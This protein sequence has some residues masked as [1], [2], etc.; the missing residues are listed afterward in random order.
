MC[1]IIKTRRGSELATWAIKTPAQAPSQHSH[2]TKHPKVV[3]LS[4]GQKLMFRYIILSNI[5][6]FCWKIMRFYFCSWRNYMKNS[7]FLG[8]FHSLWHCKW[9]NQVCV[10]ISQDM[11]LKALSDNVVS[12]KSLSGEFHFFTYVTRAGHAWSRTS[13]I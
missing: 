6:N 11:I 3:R 7:V 9:Y 1:Q 2:I 4:F 13:S 8:M 10:P 5:S 12:R